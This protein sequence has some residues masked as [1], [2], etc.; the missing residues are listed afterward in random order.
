M[1]NAIARINNISLN[2]AAQLI[3]QDKLNQI[4]GEE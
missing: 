3:L 4:T 2:D 1:V